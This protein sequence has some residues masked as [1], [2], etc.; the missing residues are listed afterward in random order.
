[1]ILERIFQGLSIGTDQIL[2]KLDNELAS[3]FVIVTYI[4]S[5]LP[6]IPICLS[7][8]MDFISILL[9]LFNESILQTDD[10]SDSSEN[11][12]DRIMKANLQIPLN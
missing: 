2:Y 5:Y 4:I 9:I 11:A 12:Y 6:I 7:G 1:M 8:L 10:T 3:G